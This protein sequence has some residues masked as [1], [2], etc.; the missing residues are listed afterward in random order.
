MSSAYSIGL[1][2]LIDE[3]GAGMVTVGSLDSSRRSELLDGVRVS[4]TVVGALED[5]ARTLLMAGVLEKI[6]SH[7]S[8]KRSMEV[9]VNKGVEVGGMFVNDDIEENIISS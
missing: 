7:S 1:S 9:F 3:V 6:V 2:E 8:G 4:T 5:S